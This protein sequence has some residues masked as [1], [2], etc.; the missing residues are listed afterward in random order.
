MGKSFELNPYDR[1]VVNKMMNGK[2]CTLVWYVDK[3]KLSHMEAKV[4]EDLINIMKNHFGQLLLTRLK[5]YI[6]GVMNINITEDKKL[7]YK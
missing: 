6:F 7:I 2:Q 5:K 4:E 1:C 3:N